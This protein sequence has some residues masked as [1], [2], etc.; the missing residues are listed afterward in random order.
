MAHY[1]E[2]ALDL[3]PESTEEELHESFRE[4]MASNRDKVLFY[5]IGN[6]FVSFIHLSIRVDYVEGTESSPTGY[7]EGVY[8]KPEFRRKGYSAKLVEV[9][10]EWLKKNGCKQ[11]GSDIHLDNHVS[12]DFHIGMGFKESSRLIAFIKNIKG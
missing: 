6:E 9:G 5:R 12:Y 11:I 7:I 4:I 2:M 3:W 1:T 10:E 8:V